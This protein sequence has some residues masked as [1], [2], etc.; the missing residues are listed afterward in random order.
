[1]I[2]KIILGFTLTLLVG[3]AFG[4]V[5]INTQNPTSSLDVNGSFRSTEDILVGGTEVTPGSA[6]IAGQ[7]LTSKGAGFAPE[8]QT[9]TMP[10]P[11]TGEWFLIGSFSRTDTKGGFV[12]DSDSG[13]DAY[14]SSYTVR[15]ASGSS[16]NVWTMVGYDTKSWKEFEDFRFEMSS[17]DT[18]VRVVISVQVLAQA[19]W[20]G[21]SNPSYLR[22]V[23]QSYALAAFRHTATSGA[24]NRSR[25]TMEAVRQGSCRGSR[26]IGNN[27]PSSLCTMIATIDVPAN[28]AS[29]FSIL[30]T[31]RA[32]QGTATATNKEFAIGRMLATT[33]ENDVLQ[34][35]ATMR[36][37]IFKKITP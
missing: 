5:G 34:R 16:G 2:K 36:V 4:Q 8:W 10:V 30:A 25:A 18:P 3:N 15:Q 19:Y 13:A 17:F 28:E 24:G 26:H 23:W 1:M 27:S 32:S 14:T 7:V 9:A 6:G 21:E 29:V 35:Q 20:D 11:D 31:A 37:D 22:D 33:T 12:F